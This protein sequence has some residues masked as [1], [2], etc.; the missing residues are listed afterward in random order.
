MT[1]AAG[2]LMAAVIQLAIAQGLTM[3]LLVDSTGYRNTFM[4]SAAS[5]LLGAFF[6]FLT[7]RSQVRQGA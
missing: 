5:L 7:S 6:A 3:G 1:T 2:G 4:A